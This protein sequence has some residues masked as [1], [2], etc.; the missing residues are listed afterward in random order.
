MLTTLLSAIQ[1]AFSSFTRGFLIVALVPM[2]LF[3][4]AN[5]ALLSAVNRTWYSTLKLGAF[6]DVSSFLWL[7]GAAA[8]A[9]VLGALQPFLYRLTEGQNM[10]SFL[11]WYWHGVQRFRLD[12]MRAQAEAAT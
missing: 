12:C 9:L 3:I 5:A 2:V 1:G 6:S 10:P 4:A 7:V 8:A 11:R